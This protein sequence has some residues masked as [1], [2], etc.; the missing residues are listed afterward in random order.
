M[1]LSSDRPFDR[2]GAC[3]HWVYRVEGLLSF[4]WREGTE[5]IYCRWDRGKGGIEELS[6]WFLDMF[7]PLYL[8]LERSN[9]LLHAS[10]VVSEKGALL[11]VA[12]SGGG[13]S[14]LAEAFE[15]EGTSLLFDDKGL[16][17]YDDGGFRT[18]GST[19]YRQPEPHEPGLGPSFHHTTGHSVPIETIYSL[20]IVEAVAEVK[21]DLLRGYR[22]FTSLWPAFLHTFPWCKAERIRFLSKLIGEIGI[23][24]LQIPRTRE[25]LSE[26]LECIR[27]HRLL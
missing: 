22:T 1:T 18:V 21:V 12:P 11:F 8:T 27:T 24:R 20:E 7:L 15:A 25:R 9:D 23:Y 13:K 5:V 6:Y 4:R 14:T 2:E 16:I 3:R 26:V 17:L 19:P 10:A